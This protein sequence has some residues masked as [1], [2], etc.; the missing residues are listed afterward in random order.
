MRGQR[1]R[2]YEAIL[3]GPRHGACERRWVRAPETGVPGG[4]RERQN[5]RPR[6]Q[7]AQDDSPF[8]E[9]PDE[10]ASTIVNNHDNLMAKRRATAPQPPATL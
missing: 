4:Q 9:H 1:A 6:R 2:G 7:A 5:E 10:K 8:H 3:M